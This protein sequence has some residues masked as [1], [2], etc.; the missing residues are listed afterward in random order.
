MRT[1]RRRPLDDQTRLS[2]ELL[3]LGS[4]PKANSLLI[5]QRRF[6]VPGIGLEIRKEG[7]ARA[8]ADG[9][10][11][12]RADITTLKPEDFP[13]VRYVM[14]DNVLEHL[15]SVEEA[16]EVVRVACSLA[17]RA[18]YIRHPSF[19]Q[20]EYL[21]EIGVKQY[22]TDWPDAHTCPLQVHELIEL[23]ARAGVYRYVVVPVLRAEDSSDPTLIPVG[24][25]PSQKRQPGQKHGIYDAERHGAKPHVRFDRPVYFAFDVVLLTSPM[26]PRLEY[27]E[28]PERSARRPW[29]HWPDEDALGSG[30]AGGSGVEPVETAETG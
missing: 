26:I 29:F 30:A 16:A 4:G 7:V 25:P 15:S 13:A 5:A 10:P 11:V 8:Q 21:A 18:V 22:W 28:D 24:C 9:H 20:M 12:F 19:E 23:A 2:A 1:P 27:R 6:G 14:I 17:S 3:D